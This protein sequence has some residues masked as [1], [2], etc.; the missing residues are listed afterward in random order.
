[1]TKT[2]GIRSAWLVNHSLSRYRG[3]GK[4]FGGCYRE[5]VGERGR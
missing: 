2:G 5:A 3:G 4:K 1:M